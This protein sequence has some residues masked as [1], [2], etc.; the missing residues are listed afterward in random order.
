M[1]VPRG[2]VY[3]TKCTGREAYGVLQNG[4][5]KGQIITFNTERER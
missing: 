5:I 4:V 3:V 1:R 2:V